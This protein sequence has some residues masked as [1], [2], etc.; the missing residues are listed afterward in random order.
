MAYDQAKRLLKI[1]TNLGADT[2]LLTELDG[3]DEL[4]RPFL[5]KIRI[6][7]DKPMDEVKGLLATPVT[8]EF[9]AEGT[10]QARRPFRGYVRR[11]IRTSVV[12]AARDEWEWQAEIVPQLWF[13][14]LRTNMCIHKDVTFPDIVSAMFGDYGATA[15]ELRATSFASTV[16]DFC[17]QYRETDL[18]FL[19][20]TM[21]RFGWFYFHKHEAA[22]TKLIVGDANLHGD[23]QILI[24]AYD[25]VSLEDDFSVQPGQCSFTEFDPLNFDVTT[26]TRPR[27][28]GGAAL[29]TA[30]ERYDYPGA[31]IEK[32]GEP[33]EMGLEGVGRDLT[34]VAME[35]EEA[36]HYLRR[37]AGVE[38]RL[39]PGRRVK[40]GSAGLEALVTA[41]THRARD[42]SHWTEADWGKQE[43]TAPFYENRFTCIPQSVP[44]RPE[45]ITPRPVV[46]GPQT[47]K[48]V[49]GGDSEQIDSHGR[50]KLKFH[51]DRDQ[52]GSAW[53]RVSQGWAGNGFGQM[54]IPRTGDEVIVEF[55][56]GNP[57]RPIVTGRVYNGRN[58]VPFAL[59][60]NRW[61]SGIK[62]SRNNQLRFDD[63][64]DEEEVYTR[65]AKSML[66]EVVD[67]ETHKVGE[68]SGTGDRTT[69]I[70]NNDTLTVQQGS[71]TTTV[72]TG[73]ATIEAK[74]EMLLKV[75]STKVT[76]KPDSV[77]IEATNQIVLK[78]GGSKVTVSQQGVT[79]EGT[80]V[81][82]K[83]T[84]SAKLESPMTTAGGSGITRVTGSLIQV[85]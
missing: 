31:F 45:A 68:G 4:S 64:V 7:T 8:L 9:G 39:D 29:N 74:T 54:H 83:G 69:E 85:G 55:L 10:P 44:F 22:A 28:I 5:F 12:N 37:G 57:D 67:T 6:V 51:W 59:N 81:E 65:A 62:T 71:L 47:A 15:P 1:T 76:L 58:A 25:L 33:D 3:V 14:S 32:S 52:R 30:H 70:K 41:V 16:L 38:P 82:V 75:E 13:M 72:E 36:R 43:P 34:D 61:Q 66:T 18:A 23:E 50:V 26:Q 21:E 77:E 42:Y 49:L 79:V 84:G 63:K 35:R 73:S 60:A 19:S 11:L 17:V 20:R 2:V 40:F 46:D 80:M 78:V 56:E 24:D 27:K 48:V 53:V